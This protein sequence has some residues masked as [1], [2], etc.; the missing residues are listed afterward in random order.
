MA[1]NIK[2]PET[3]RLARD[4]AELTGTTITHALRTALRHELEAAR[5]RSPGEVEQRRRAMQAIV[6]RAR[7]LP[8]LDDRPVDELLDYDE[9]GLPS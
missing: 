4:L 6:E 9:S 2:D 1:L 5:R 3:D 7:E 8:V